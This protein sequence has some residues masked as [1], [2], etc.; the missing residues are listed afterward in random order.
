MFFFEKN[1]GDKMFGLS[2]LS[3][4]VILKQND[5]FLDL[6]LP[7]LYR[8][9]II[10]HCLRGIKLLKRIDISR[11]RKNYSFTQTN[12]K[13]SLEMQKNDGLV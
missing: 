5:V 13:P 11:F 4:S 3:S 7:K 1:V 6:D 8:N 2:H 12:Y 10:K 9:M